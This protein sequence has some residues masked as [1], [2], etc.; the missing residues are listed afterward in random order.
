MLKTN[1]INVNALPLQVVGT[2]WLLSRYFDITQRED[3]IRLFIGY[4]IF[5]IIVFLHTFVHQ[6]PLTAIVLNTL[7][8]YH[9]CLILLSN[10]WQPKPRATLNIEAMMLWYF[11]V[12]SIMSDY[13]LITHIAEKGWAERWK[14]FGSGT[15]HGII[16][17]T[18]LVF[19]LEGA[20]LKRTSRLVAW[21]IGSQLI[22]ALL[23]LQS[24][25]ILAA[26]VPLM[27]WQLVRYYKAKVIFISI[28]LG[29]VIFLL[30]T[31]LTEEQL[32]FLKR[33][34]PEEYQDLESFTSGRLETQ[35]YIVDWLI[36]EAPLSEQFTGIGL[37][38]IKELAYAGALEYPHFDLLYVIFEGGFSLLVF[39][40]VYTYFLIS[41]SRDAIYQL[42]FMSGSLHANMVAMPHVLILMFLLSYCSKVRA[43]RLEMEQEA[44]IQ[45]Q[46]EA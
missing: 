7:I 22:L 30:A 9:V 33:F 5:A 6:I 11:I 16:A 25:G 12:F 1:G 40:L 15:T 13:Y 45:Q 42:S 32:P 3:L 46:Q 21:L 2:F 41:R 28:P 37:N 26:A 14:G 29:L 10:N 27:G 31:T 8:V 43:V 35:E 44:K 39:Y 24:R 36:N 20:I 4:F 17:M 18:G 34:N 19:L 23:A 38:K